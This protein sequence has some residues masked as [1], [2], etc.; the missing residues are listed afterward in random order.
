V[1]SHYF[2]YEYQLSTG[3]RQVF[4]GEV[5]VNIL[6][7]PHQVKQLISCWLAEVKDR[8]AGSIDHSDLKVKNNNKKL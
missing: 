4:L 5:K 1:C 6:V 8:L 2:I 3:H 7:L